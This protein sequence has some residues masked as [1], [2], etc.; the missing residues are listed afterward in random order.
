VPRSPRLRHCRVRSGATGR[1]RSR[2][3]PVV[4]IR[5]GRVASSQSVAIL[6]WGDLFAD[7]LDQLG[8]SLAEFRDEFTGSW[9]FGY[10][11]ALQ[12]AGARPFLVCTTTRVT[13]LQR[14]VHRPTG[15]PLYL[16]P[17]ARP[18]RAIRRLL[19]DTSLGSKRD[20]VSVGR[21]IATH[22]APYVATPPRTLARVLRAERCTSVLVQEYET[23]RFDVCV[24]LGRM[25]HLP[26]F[27]T[28]Q[29]GDYQLSRLEAPIRPL[30]LRLA[31]GLIVAPRDERD[32]LRRRYGMRDGKV[33]GIY[34]P[35]DAGFWRA[36]DRVASRAAE[37]L[38]PDAEIVVWHGQAHPRKGLDL[39]LDAW[40]RVRAERPERPL[41]L[42]LFG[43]RR[44]A[45]R[46]RAEVGR[47]SALSVH[48]IDEWILD[49]KRVRRLLSAADI[50]AF[51]SRHEGFPIA[52]LEAMAC[53]LPVVATDVLGVPDI[54]EAG[55][56]HGGV[57][58]PHD[59]AA[60]ASSLGSVLDDASRRKSLALAARERIE[61]AFSM[62]RVG[63]ELAAFLGSQDRRR[64]SSRR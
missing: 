52:P 21:A 12:H 31:A 11:R 14:G 5:G 59:A 13:S 29:G 10:A 23:P 39:L 38:P 61:S 55:E 45:D 63:G 22:V 24:A 48:V 7:W 32:R 15:I 49:P 58:V 33:R 17:P 57:V 1:A 30:S 53:G 8:I 20:P 51:P 2:F 37:G 18:Y 56:G 26:V 16:L 25:L 40:R 3:A 19:L 50:Y 41:L 4:S 47:M 43:G 62:E 54:F 28:F 6:P 9:M 46:L 64:E 34:N 42:M 35:I 44:G 27:G 36:D 60:F